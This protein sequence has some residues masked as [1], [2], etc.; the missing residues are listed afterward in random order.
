MNTNENTEMDL[1]PIF[2]NYV[3]NYIKQE[4]DK[5]DFK[6]H[7]TFDL[8]GEKDLPSSFNLSSLTELPPVL[9]QG[10]IG[11]CTA[12]CTSS[13]LRYSLRLNKLWEFQPSRLF[14]YYFTREIEG[15]TGE[16]AGATLRNTMKSV[17]RK[18]ACTEGTWG[19]DSSKL[20]TRPSSLAIIEGKAHK[21][22]FKYFRIKRNLGI[23][24]NALVSG[25]PIVIGIAVYQSFVTN[26]VAK[27]GTVHLPD[28]G[29]EKLLG[30][31]A[32]LMV[33]YDDAT[34]RFTFK[35]SW[36]T[37][38]GANGFFTLPYNY[39]M[40]KSLAMDMWAIQSFK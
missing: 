2:S 35:N 24:K 3:F 34:E 39:V 28:K 29:R 14:I 16:D 33:G 37:G 36:G 8:K 12:N 11:S 22:G 27:T 9:D 1:H 10:N 13:A 5:R 25:F 40:D 18:G 23:M 31:H 15:T 4:K 32:I 19:Y 6:F 30:G 7:L 21:K 38:W 26:A 20:T 17:N